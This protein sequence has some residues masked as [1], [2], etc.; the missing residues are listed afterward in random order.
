M[1]LAVIIAAAGSATRMGA[2]KN[3]ALLPLAGKPVLAHTLKTACVFADEVVIAARPGE[4]EEVA[5]IAAAFPRVRHIVSG[6]ATRSDSVRNALA[7]IS[8]DADMVAIHDAARPLLHESDF[9]AVLAAAEAHGAAILAAPVIDTIKLNDGGLVGDTVDRSRLAAAQTP[10]VFR[11]ALLDAAYAAADASATDDAA[12]VE[13]L[14]QRV[15]LVFA[16]HPNFKLTTPA[17]MQMAAAIIG[18]S[19][20]LPRVGLGYDVH[21]LTEGRRL[22]VGGVDI[23]YAKGLLGH[24]DADVLLHAIS[25]AILGAAALGDIGKHFPPGR[26]E[27]KDADSLLLLAHCGKL[28][29]EAGYR[30]HNIDATI[31]AEAPKMAP[32]IPQ[33]R[34]NIASALGIDSAAVSIKATTTEKLGFCGRGEGM[35]AEAIATIIPL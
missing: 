31:I 9:A 35:A 10:Q 17:D 16:A 14:G 23:P 15:Q 12:L 22:I 18:G 11:R 29:Q 7:A 4:E 24:S 25:D 8:A 21:Q 32:H 33:M 5:A 6:G 26:P 20:P 19:A 1:K 34:A 13:A 28:V 2:G 3:K 30:V 27:W